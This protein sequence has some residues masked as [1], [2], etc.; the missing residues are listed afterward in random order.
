M[1]FKVIHIDKNGHRRKARVTA[2]SSQDAAD[3]MDREF[4]DARGGS[5]LRLTQRPVLSV[6]ERGGAQRGARA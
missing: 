3:Q 4:G 5:C 2:R 6:V 1:I